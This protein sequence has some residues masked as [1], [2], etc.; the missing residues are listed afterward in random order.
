MHEYILNDI[1]NNTWLSD[2]YGNIRI[3]F[4][5]DGTQYFIFDSDNN[6][7]IEVFQTVGDFYVTE[8]EI[9]MTYS[10]YEHRPYVIVL[11]K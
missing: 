10:D 1:V 5:F 4:A 3:G 6:A 11:T 9:K 2:L 8:N 7:I